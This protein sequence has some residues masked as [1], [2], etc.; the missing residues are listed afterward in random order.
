MLKGEFVDK[1]GKPK[2]VDQLYV[3][4]RFIIS[5]QMA[6]YFLI[7][8]N[9]RT[10]L[11]AGKLYTKEHAREIFNIIKN[12]KG[13][14]KIY[15]PED[16]R[17]N[18]ERLCL[19]TEGK[20]PNAIAYLD[21]YDIKETAELNITYPDELMNGG[22]LGMQ[23][24]YFMTYDEN[25]KIDEFRDITVDINGTPTK[26]YKDTKL[27]FP[28]SVLS[29]DYLGLINYGIPGHDV[30][31]PLFTDI[32]PKQLYPHLEYLN[33]LELILAHEYL[34]AMQSM[35]DPALQ[36]HRDIGQIDETAKGYTKEKHKIPTTAGKTIDHHIRRSFRELFAHHFSIFP[37]KQYDDPAEDPVFK[38]TDF[39]RGKTAV[40]GG[41]SE[42]KVVFWVFRA[43][44]YANYLSGKLGSY[45]NKE[46]VA[47][48]ESASKDIYNAKR[49]Y[50]TK[51]YKF[52][53]EE[54]AG[55][56]VEDVLKI[57]AKANAEMLKRY[58]DMNLSEPG[59][60]KEEEEV[61]EE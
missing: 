15:N 61:T 9:V 55:K 29:F 32:N 48:A 5:E 36:G 22:R 56:A 1:D 17:K 10:A 19:S 18:K 47:A 14:V 20:N 2:K 24:D 34:H 11:R 21:R 44:D 35:L 3:H 13:L 6:L 8:E 38:F 57:F 16:T 30:N 31:L 40:F 27:V 58:T 33:E 52:P 39:V 43:L 49:C 60:Q 46:L 50:E 23:Q 4:E 45:Y 54:A 25:F 59:I 51:G 28:V 7:D 41:L 12:H 42:P 37:N 53:N 26:K